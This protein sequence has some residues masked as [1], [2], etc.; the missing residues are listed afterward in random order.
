MKQTKITAQKSH[1]SNQDDTL[2]SKSMEL[3]QN[4]TTTT[5]TTTTTASSAAKWVLAS[6]KS[7]ASTHTKSRRRPIKSLVGNRKRRLLRGANQIQIGAIVGQS[8]ITENNKSTASLDTIVVVQKALQEPSDHDA[9]EPIVNATAASRGFPRKPSMLARDLM[10]CVR[11][12][13]LPF[14]VL[15]AKKE[16]VEFQRSKGRL[17]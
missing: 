1:I 17:V 7:S 15:F 16:I 4:T 13:L 11:L 10:H 5:T 12:A 8:R 9:A 14:H 3:A 2:I 6:T